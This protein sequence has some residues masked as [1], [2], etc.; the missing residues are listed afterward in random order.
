MSY[1]VLFL[2]TFSC[3]SVNNMSATVNFTNLSLATFLLAITNL[4][5]NNSV[6]AGN[7]IIDNLTIEDMENK[8]FE[9]RMK[10]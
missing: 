7:Y 4:C 6:K 9:S 3:S 2:F 1:E 8:P 5:T 10:Y